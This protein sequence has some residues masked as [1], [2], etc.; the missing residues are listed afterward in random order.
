MSPGN[1]K[2][3]S[4]EV[5]CPRREGDELLVRAGNNAGSVDGEAQK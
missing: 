1:K 5:D 3:E 2:L 4:N